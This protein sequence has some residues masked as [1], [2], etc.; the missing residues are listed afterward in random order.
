[1]KRKIWSALALLAGA[2]LLAFELRRAHGVN[3]DNVFWVL[4]GGLLVVLSVID[5]VQR[6]PP[7]DE[8]PPSDDD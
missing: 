8:K 2:A 3:A 1:V 5:L 6:R 4:I 7:T